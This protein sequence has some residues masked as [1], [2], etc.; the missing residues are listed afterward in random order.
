MAFGKDWKKWE[1]LR[2]HLLKQPGRLQFMINSKNPEVF[3]SVLDLYEQARK[4]AEQTNTPSKFLKARDALLICLRSYF[5][6]KHEMFCKDAPPD[7]LSKKLAELKE[8][9]V[10]VTLNWDT[11]VE[12][13]LLENN[14][15]APTDGYGFRQKLCLDTPQS[16]KKLLTK[17]QNFVLKLHGSVGWYKNGDHHLYFDRDFLSHFPFPSKDG[18]RCVD[19]QQPKN[20][21]CPDPA[22]MAYP[23]YLKK[24]AGPEMQQV[25]HRAAKAL[26]KAHVIEIWGYSLPESDTAIRIL[27]NIL[28]FRSKIQINVHEPCA[29]ARTRWS[30]FLNGSKGTRTVCI[31]CQKLGAI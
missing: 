6:K 28:R 27:L 19:P 12:R 13:T 29:T 23:T 2:D 10:G 17:S 14:R 11:T 1:C 18:P 4:E 3:L 15:W 26:R 22:V 31:D 8:G 25:W 30:K 16:D 20:L 24:L 21:K 9:D 5:E 7:Y